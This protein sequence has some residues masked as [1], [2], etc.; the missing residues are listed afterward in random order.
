MTAITIKLNLTDD[1]A[2]EYT[3]HKEIYK[4]KIKKFLAA[5]LKQKTAPD[6]IIADSSLSKQE[7]AEEEQ[8]LQARKSE[9][10]QRLQEDESNDI[11]A[12]EFLKTLK[13]LKKD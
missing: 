8:D 2:M 11:D 1:M 4:K 9:I 3:N 13:N 6:F 12:F 10:E 5:E 7:L